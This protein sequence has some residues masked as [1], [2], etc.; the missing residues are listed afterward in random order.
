MKKKLERKRMGSCQTNLKEVTEPEGSE[1]LV[2]LELVRRLP[3]TIF[4]T[5]KGANERP[6]ERNRSYERNPIE[7]GRKVFLYE[8]YW[9]Q[10]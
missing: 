2:G 10:R 1:N 4:G 7:K 3:Q 6:P 9:L 5:K 8:R